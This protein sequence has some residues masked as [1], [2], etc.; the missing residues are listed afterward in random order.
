MFGCGSPSNNDTNHTTS[1]R[2]EGAKAALV[3]VHDTS[4]ST[5]LSVRDDAG[6]HSVRAHHPHVDA[7]AARQVRRRA[8]A[9]TPRVPRRHA[10][11]ESAV[12]GGGNGVMVMVMAS[13]GGASRTGT[14]RTKRGGVRHATLIGQVGRGAVLRGANQGGPSNEES[15]VSR[16]ALRQEGGR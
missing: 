16:S 6:D 15:L 14:S 2:C 5:G 3:E 10:H 12:N 7:R 11:P 9:G 8:L 4:G 13:G 1:Q